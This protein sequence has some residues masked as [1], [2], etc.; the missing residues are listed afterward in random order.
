MGNLSKKWNNRQLKKFR[1]RDVYISGNHKTF[2]VVPAHSLETHWYDA[3]YQFRDD[4]YSYM[5]YDDA[6]DRLGKMPVGSYMIF[7]EPWAGKNGSW[8]YIMKN[9]C[10]GCS[11]SKTC[12]NKRVTVKRK[13][14][15]DV[16]IQFKRPTKCEL[17]NQFKN[18]TYGGS[19]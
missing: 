3:I 1:Q 7:Y 17:K 8:Q 11:G 13:F 9:R 16:K 14:G 5:N 4:V 2:I 10:D 19:L 18:I 6:S 12:G 15:K